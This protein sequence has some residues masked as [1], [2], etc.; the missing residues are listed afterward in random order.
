MS[1]SEFEQDSKIEIKEERKTL[2]REL[3]PEVGESTL[4]RPRKE[5]K[6]D[7]LALKSSSSRSALHGMHG[8]AF[9]GNTFPGKNQAGLGSQKFPIEI[10]GSSDDEND[11]RGRE[12]NTFPRKTQAALALI[13]DDNTDGRGRESNKTTLASNHG[14]ASSAAA[15][16]ADISLP[17]ALDFQSKQ[18]QWGNHLYERAK[19]A[20]E[21]RRKKG[22]GVQCC[23]FF[24]GACK[25]NY[26]RGSRKTRGTAKACDECFRMFNLNR[27]GIPKGKNPRDSQPVPPS[28]NHEGERDSPG[29]VVLRRADAPLHHRG[30]HRGS[31][32]ESSE[33]DPHRQRDG[34][35]PPKATARLPVI[36]HGVH[37]G[38][39]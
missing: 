10:G 34:V 28:Q 39:P 7:R 21:L 37:Q 8:K 13:T 32:G 12:G 20:V 3:E 17:F 9:P 30:L 23:F 31:R 2:K 16:A 4:R 33:I 6:T 15:L 18:P 36:R 24:F 22:G 29:D 19:D 26:T 38:G 11:G 5:Q 25:R 14:E 27:S 1:S 35:Q